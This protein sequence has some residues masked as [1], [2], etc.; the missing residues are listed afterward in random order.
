MPFFGNIHYRIAAHRAI[1]FG[2]SSYLRALFDT[3]LKEKNQHAYEI[4]EV[5]GPTLEIVIEYCYK[6]KIDLNRDNVDAIFMAASFLQMTE[7]ETTCIQFYKRMMQPSNCLGIWNIAEQY[8]LEDLKNYTREF[9]LRHFVKVANSA[10]LEHISSTRL[11]EIL[12]S[13]DLKI[14]GEEEIFSVSM[15]WIQFDT[16]QRKGAFG[17]LIE[18]VRF[19][20]VRR[21]VNFF[22]IFQSTVDNY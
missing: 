3:Q 20:H 9:T 19:A 6:H 21:S 5:N 12:G 17:T 2:A 11:S 7:L 1:L 15:R 4:P 13:D 16:E 10:E 8:T 18:N 14:D 22:L